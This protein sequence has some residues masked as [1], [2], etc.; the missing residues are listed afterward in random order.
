[1]NKAF[2]II[3]SHARNAFVVVDELAS[4]AGKR[5]LCKKLLATLGLSLVASA[6]HAVMPPCYPSTTITSAN[7]MTSTCTM[8]TGVSLSVNAGGSITTTSTASVVSYDG[9]DTITNAGLISSTGNYG[10]TLTAGEISASGTAVNNLTGALIKGTAGIH[11]GNG[12]SA[13]S[14]GSIS[15]AGTIQGSTGSGIFLQKSSVG[16]VINSSEGEIKGTTSDGI[17]LETSSHIGTIDNEG[18]IF[19]SYVGIGVYNSGVNHSDIDSIRNS[20]TIQGGQ[21]SI[22]ANDAETIDSIEIAGTSARLIGDVYAVNSDF[23][24]KSAAV[25][26]NENAIRVKSFTVE[27]GATFNMGAGPSLIAITPGISVTNGF[28]NDGT[29][30]LAP[31]ISGTIHGNYTQS[32]TGALQF[33]VTDDNNYGKLVVAGDATLPSNARV[34][35][36]VSNPNHQ[37][38]AAS[39]N[40]VISATTLHSDGT[41]AVSDNSLLF[42]FGAVK[43][44]NNVNL[45]LAAAPVTPPAPE[46]TPE[47]EPTPA[48]PTPAP[49]PTPTPTPT[50]EPTPAP[51]PTPEPT[52]A[53]T[54]APEPTPAPTPAPEPT[55][56]PNPGVLGSVIN[57]GNNPARGA[58]HVLDGVIS[59]SPTGELASHFVA[60]TNQ[61]QVSDAVSQTLPLLTGSSSG[62]TSNTLTGI[63]Q[64]VQARQ[65]STSGLS[66]GDPLLSDENAWIKPFG[67]W[68][69]QNDR[70]G[71]SGFNANTHGLALGIDAAVSE[72][73]RLGLAFAYARTDVDSNS[74]I[75]PQSLQVDTYQLIGYGS[76]SLATD[77]DLNFQVDAGQ[78]RNEGKRHMPFADA[79]A[80]A[81]YDS[82]SFH[83]GVGLDHSLHFS[84]Q[85]TFIPSVRADYTWIEDE[86]YTEKG[87]GALDLDVDSRDAEAMILSVDGKLGYRLGA[88]TQLDANLGAGYDLIN[89]QT[90]ITSTY[91]GAADAAFTTR[92][93][94][95]S[96]WL[97]RAGLGLTHNLSNGTEV[98]LRY[99]VESRS[100]FLNQG[101]S[102]KAR[103][104]F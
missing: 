56:A 77:T 85:L 38:S 28:I 68:A 30:K 84:E 69:D 104:A 42:D 64:V 60:L 75:A 103:W 61:Q 2:R 94:D 24:V 101:A 3:W 49:E 11:I 96:P 14:V 9:F 82:H 45:T 63:N 27:Q 53:P 89:E 81:D 13:M 88:Q 62:A 16:S 31:G 97:T 47:P 98:S 66:S 100:D 23:S 20:G 26:S 6:A 87:A 41:F 18:L 32:S 67:S 37:F 33:G 65:D 83:A 90:S 7:S 48:P 15:N 58:A 55:P 51:A 39:L 34:L 80:R 40:N 5:S 78:H 35:V 102:I 21:I 73:T 59:Q 50:P 1:M 74:D 43:D 92:G 36:D 19:G 29:V 76:Y 52:P 17:H 4:A 70:N 44:G 86:S 91:A 46:P 25:F 54:P 99:D 71:V 72:Q 79:T 8:G 93:L 12:Y 22:G 57:T 95:P 10:I